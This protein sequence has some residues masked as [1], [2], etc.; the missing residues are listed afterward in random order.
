MTDNEIIKALEC[1]GGD[2]ISCQSCAY[3]PSGYPRCKEN[4][5]KDAIDLINRQKA[6]SERLKECPRCVYEFDSEVM[7]FCS[8]SPCP[9]YKTADEI[10]AEAIKEFAEKLKENAFETKDVGETASAYLTV[11][12]TGII[13][14]LVKEMEKKYE[15]S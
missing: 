15:I 9:N 6:E 10:R 14:N 12:T 1:L 4:C 2:S 7:E 13:D 8:Q 5:A 3:A 11:V